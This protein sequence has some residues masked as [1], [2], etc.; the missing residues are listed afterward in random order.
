MRVI[1][2]EAIHS[3]GS[4]PIDALKDKIDRGV[5][6]GWVNAV[7]IGGDA[8]D[9]IY[10]QLD[11]SI[12]KNMDVEYQ[13]SSRKLIIDIR[14]ARHSQVRLEADPRTLEFDESGNRFVQKSDSSGYWSITF[15]VE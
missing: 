7:S 8:M 15:A 5:S 12:T 4:T 6:I 14:L 11:P 1:K 2:T 10:V 9:D 3:E 13:V